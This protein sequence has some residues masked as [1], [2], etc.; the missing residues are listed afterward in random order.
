M[1][2]KQNVGRFEVSSKHWWLWESVSVWQMLTMRCFVGVQQYLS[3]E[4]DERV[5]DDITKD[6]HRQFPFHEMFMRKTGGGQQDLFRVLKAYSI[7]S[8]QVGWV[9][10]FH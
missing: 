7:H 6:L 9:T 8:P 1:D 3:E 5:I 2:A 4:G 10:T